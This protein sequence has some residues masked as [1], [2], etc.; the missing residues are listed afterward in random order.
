M[1]VLW[2][3]NHSFINKSTHLKE[4]S[5]GGGVKRVDIMK[6]AMVEVKNNLDQSHNQTALGGQVHRRSVSGN[7]SRAKVDQVENS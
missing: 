5:Q 4:L 2:I 3:A 6:L 1:E 7:C